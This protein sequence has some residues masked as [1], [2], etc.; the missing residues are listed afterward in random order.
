MDMSKA[1]KW[2]VCGLAIAVGAWLAWV[3]FLMYGIYKLVTL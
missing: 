1:E 2:L 3:L